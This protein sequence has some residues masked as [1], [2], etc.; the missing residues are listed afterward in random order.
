MEAKLNNISMEIYGKQIQI[1]SDEELYI[2][3]LE[4]TKRE[5]RQ[6][7]IIS[8]PKKVYYIS[9]EFLIGKLLS[10]NLINLKLY[11]EIDELHILLHLSFCFG[12]MTGIPLKIHGKYF[13]TEQGEILPHPEEPCEVSNHS[14]TYDADCA[15]MPVHRRPSSPIHRP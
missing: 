15:V 12:H 13:I 3:L 5:M 11:D 14:V 9:A 6:K 8:G 1:C 10:N 2:V 4:F 7:K